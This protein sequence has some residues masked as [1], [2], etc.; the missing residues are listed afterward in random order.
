MD[1][2]RQSRLAPALIAAAVLLPGSLLVVYVA[3]YF[4]LGELSVS[5]RNGHISSSR[6]FPG[7]TVDMTRNFERQWQADLYK[8]A[9]A[10]ESRLRGV[11]VKLLSDE[12]FMGIF[13]V[14]Q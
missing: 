8:P 2:K 9:A 1:E 4:W 3:G 5:H 10:V 11:E 12:E 7:S 13:S 14:D 6:P